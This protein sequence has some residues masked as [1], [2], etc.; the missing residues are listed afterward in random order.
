MSQARKVL[1]EQQ[2]VQPAM[3]L[4]QADLLLVVHRFKVPE[5]WTAAKLTSVRI[6]PIGSLK[7]VSSPSHFSF[8]SHRQLCFRGTI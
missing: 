4:S 2:P 3:M 6:G 8:Q 5:E 1:E 7:K